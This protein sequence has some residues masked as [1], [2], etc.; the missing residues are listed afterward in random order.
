MDSLPRELIIKIMAYVPT[1]HDII[2]FQKAFPHKL[3]EYDIT[4]D[5]YEYKRILT[6]K[7]NTNCMQYLY[8]IALEYNMT[9]DSYKNNIEH[10]CYH[11]EIVHYNTLTFRQ[12]H[13]WYLQI[14]NILN[15]VSNMDDNDA[16]VLNVYRFENFGQYCAVDF[17]L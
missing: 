10:C 7:G 13:P 8:A 11:R 1:F 12:N 4:H 5:V 9:P 14:F 17:I 2:Q 6:Q 16:F 15:R 3:S